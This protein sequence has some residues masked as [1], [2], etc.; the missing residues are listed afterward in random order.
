MLGTPRFAV[1]LGGPN[2]FRHARTPQRGVPTISACQI[3]PRSPASAVM[4]T[5]AKSKLPLIVGVILLLIF[6]GAYVFVLSAYKNESNNRS[7]ELQPDT[8][9]AGE[10]RID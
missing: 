7:A 6:A 8:A 4:D 9:K 1:R 10:N 5:P 3:S 2:C